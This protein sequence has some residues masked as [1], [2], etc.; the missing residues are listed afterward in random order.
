MKHI[1]NEIQIELYN[2][3]IRFAETEEEKEEVKEFVFQD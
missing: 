3:A 2:Y 1:E